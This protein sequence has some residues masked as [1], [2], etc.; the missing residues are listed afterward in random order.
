MN[1]K[2]KA[3]EKYEI[4]ISEDDIELIKTSSSKTLNKVDIDEDWDT[5][6][7]VF[8]SRDNFLDALGSCIDMQRYVKGFLR[9]SCTV[10]YSTLTNNFDNNVDKLIDGFTKYRYLHKVEQNIYLSYMPEYHNHIEMDNVLRFKQFELMMNGDKQVREEIARHYVMARDTVNYS[11][12]YVFFDNDIG[13]K[14]FHSLESY[15]ELWISP[16]VIMMYLNEKDK[17][18]YKGFMGTKVKK[19]EQEITKLHFKAI[20]NIVYQELTLSNQ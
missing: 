16:T 10:V 11:G 1:D 19:H 5:R 20:M 2:Y 6:V 13:D 14:C 18:Q 15:T 7:N 8:S 12:N 9:H 3:L 4:L 17:E